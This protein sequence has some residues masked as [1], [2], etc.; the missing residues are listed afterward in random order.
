MDTRS[1]IL[2][3]AMNLTRMGNWSADGYDKKKERIKTFLANTNQYIKDINGAPLPPSFKKTF[4]LFLREYG[5]LE[6]TGLEGP[7]NSLEW[8]EEMMTWG[9]IL[10]HRSRLL[11]LSK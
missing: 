5:Q 1:T 3:I 6:K 9:N 4:D 7:N 2:D 11:P 8:A 10:T